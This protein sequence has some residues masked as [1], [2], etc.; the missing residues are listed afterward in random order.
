M[1]DRGDIRIALANMG[2]VGQVGF[3]MAN[4]VAHPNA[5]YKALHRML[6]G[7]LVQRSDNYRE[8]HR[9]V[10]EY[11]AV[12]S[13]FI[14]P[15][16]VEQIRHLQP[17]AYWTTN[18]TVLELLCAAEKEIDFNSSELWNLVYAPALY[19]QDA[20]E[21]TIRGELSFGDDEAPRI[22][23]MTR[24]IRLGATYLSRIY[25]KD[26]LQIRQLKFLAGLF[27]NLPQPV[28]AQYRSLWEDR[29]ERPVVS[30]ESGAD[31]QR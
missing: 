17:E 14:D 23:E 22:A 13:Q 6:Y 27:R 3:A 4:R 10:E 21:E 18:K 12:A 20:D 16:L 2:P 11:R 5:V 25:S 15:R 30:L 28:L 9:L 26:S 24:M 1:N 31:G 29:D 19:Y 8:R 7:G